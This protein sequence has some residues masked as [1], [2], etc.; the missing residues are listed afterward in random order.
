MTR[1]LP[2]SVKVARARCAGTDCLPDGTFVDTDGNRITRDDLDDKVVVLNFW[3]GWNG[4]SQRDLPTLSRIA[5]DYRARDVVVLGI[6]IE[7]GDDLAIGASARQLGMRYGA[8]R[9]DTLLGMID[10]P[11]NVPTTWIYDRWGKL[12]R[13][14]V[15]AADEDE[16]TDL[17]DELLS[18]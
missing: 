16:L 14:I 11:A 9:A 10:P 5:D 2:G 8:V 15:G 1:D 17:I 13:Q 4:A 3:A 6:S 18:Q 7:A 12:E